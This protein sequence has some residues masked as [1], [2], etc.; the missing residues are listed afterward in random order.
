MSLQ[1]GK[2]TGNATA[3]SR[4][5]HFGAPVIIV[6]LMF[7]ALLVTG[8]RA[9]TVLDPD[10]ENSTTLFG[11]AIAVV[12]DV[13]GDGVPDL[14]VGTPFDDGEFPGQPGKGTPQ[15]VGKV[16]VINGA[17]QAVI[18]ELKDPQFQMQQGQQFGGQLGFS[19]AAVGDINGDGIPDVLAGI[20]HHNIEGAAS[21]PA[22]KVEEKII[23]AGRAIAYSGIDGAILHILDDSTEEEG[24]Q[25]GYAVANAGDI[26]SDGVNDLAVGVPLKDTP[27]GLTD[28]GL[29]YIYSGANGS[30]LRTLNHPSQGGAEVGARFG[31]ALANAGDINHDG[32]SDLIV[33][34]PGR[35]EAF[36]F[37]GASGAILFTVTSPTQETLPSFGS[38][39]AGGK[40]LDN[41]G[42]PDFTVGAPLLKINQGAVFIYKGS[43]G[44]LLRRLTSPDRQTFASFGA[45]VI[46]SDDVTG[47]G[48]PDV[49]VGAPE[50]DLGDLRN[51]G[52][53]YVFRG[54]N[55]RLFTTLTSEVTQ[56]FAGFGF[57]LAT[58]DFN[59]DEIL[60]TVIGVPFQTA[61]IMDPHGDIVTHLQIGQIEIH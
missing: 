32:V 44:T 31:E 9:T 33:G 17:T 16:F 45:A 19:V 6:A 47:D 10:P 25:F 18:T 12:G 36:V 49:L 22:G 38:A 8:I 34:A 27:E 42:T 28:V 58:A 59:G 35:G 5:R 4:S 61:D 53:V 56:A 55:G 20:P 21:R 57:A 13:N 23:N 15:N 52:K 51:A 7:S 26:N 39:V 50:Q 54:A 29:V 37:S 60:E 1:S 2:K 41:D 11:R 46:L 43:D 48:R 3:S 14:A 30:L 24:A 40:D